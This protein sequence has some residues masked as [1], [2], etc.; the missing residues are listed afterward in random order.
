MTFPVTSNVQ[1]RLQGCDGQTLIAF[2]HSTL[3][4]MPDEYREGL[5]RGWAPL[6]E[7]VRKQAEASQNRT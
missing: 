5:T 6:L 7:R 2:R 1:Y 4:F 3:G